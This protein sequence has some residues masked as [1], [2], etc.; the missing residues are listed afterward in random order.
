MPYTHDHAAVAGIYVTADTCH[1]R[2][3]M[4][5]GHEFPPVRSA[6]G[7]RLTRGWRGQRPRAGR[8]AEIRRGPRAKS[9][10]VYRVV[11]DVSGTGGFDDD[12]C[13]SPVREV[14]KPA[15]S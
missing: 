3:T 6:A 5:I 1:T 15:T 8:R 2:V 12:N 14:R 9:T 4:A 10:A 7:A 11:E 13:A